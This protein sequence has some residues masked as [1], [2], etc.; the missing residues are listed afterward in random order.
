M[1]KYF[2]IFSL[3]LLTVFS[4]DTSAQRW[5]LRR[6]E[7]S[8]GLGTLNFFGDIGGTADDNNLIGFKD[9]QLKFTR[10]SVFFGAAYR[11]REDMNVRMNLIFGSITGD[12]INSRNDGRNYA[13]TSTIFEPSFQFEYYLIPE[14]KTFYSSAIFNRRGMINNYAQFSAYVFL[15]IGGVLSNPKP[16]KDYVS[17]FED[18]FSKF[19]VAFPLG[20]GLKYSIDSQWSLGFEIG[21]RLTLTDHID[22]YTSKFSEHKDTYYISTFSAIYKLRTDRNGLPS[23]RRYYR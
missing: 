2:L 22:G 4:I 17:V 19:G 15:G 5:K 20:L 11:L 9:I 16:R 6:Y 8:A 23:F 21:R 18:N 13:F 14:G 1:N 12:D 3:I 7:A 10:P